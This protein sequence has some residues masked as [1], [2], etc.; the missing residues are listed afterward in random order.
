MKRTIY[1]RILPIL[2]SAV[3]AVTSFSGCGQ[4]ENT[5]PANT[6]IS[7]TADTETAVSIAET[8]LSETDDADDSSEDLTQSSVSPPS[9]PSDHKAS[10]DWHDHVGNLDTFVYGLLMNEYQL[11]YKTFNAVIVLPDETEVFGIGYTDYSEY[12]ENVVIFPTYIILLFA[13]Q[14]VLARHVF[15]SHSGSH[16]PVVQR[17]FVLSKSSYVVLLDVS[18]RR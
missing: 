11:A 13:I 15:V 2:I 10:Y 16:H 4:A 12:Y 7:S 8:I 14:I 17:Q 18:L 9:V 3:L 1:N 5:E 6:S